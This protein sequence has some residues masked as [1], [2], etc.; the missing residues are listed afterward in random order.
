MRSHCAMKI[1]DRFDRF[2]RDLEV[3]Q[4][5]QQHGFV[6]EDQRDGE[7]NIK[8]S[9]AHQSQQPKRTPASGAQSSDEDVGIDNN[10]RCGHL[11]IVNKAALEGNLVSEQE[12]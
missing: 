1:N 6:L 10:L 9:R 4:F 11:G 7:V 5:S 3:G 2:S 12:A 8:L